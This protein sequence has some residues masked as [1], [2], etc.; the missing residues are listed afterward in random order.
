MLVIARELGGARWTES[1]SQT[2]LDI[3]HDLGRAILNTRAHDRERELIAE[4]RR[5]GQYRAELISTV[6]HELKNP[7]GVI[8]G[9]VELLELLPDLPEAATTSIRALSRSASRLTSVMDDLL[10]LSRMGNSDHP[11]PRVPVD[12]AAVVREVAET[13]PVRAGAHD[14]TL[15]SAPYDGALV[16][17]GD[18]ELLLR[19]CANMVNNAVKY[20][21]PGGSVDLSVDRVD[22]E[23]VFTCTDD[24]LGISEADQV[25]LFSEFFRS[26]NPEALR[27]PGTGLGLAI[28]ARIVSRHD[29]RIEVESELGAGTTFRVSLPA[30]G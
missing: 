16:V 6:S 14:V 8:L 30:A 27:R 17:A 3:G 5:L 2:A 28:V 23:V 25:R 9:H 26:T 20:S 11:L 29:G 10:L 13:E 7:L 19:L 1:E 15:R 22:G 18:P 21:R 12:L 4:L 24:G